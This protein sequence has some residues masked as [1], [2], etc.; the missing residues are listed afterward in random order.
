MSTASSEQREITV[1]IAGAAGDGLDKTGDTL[2]HTASRLGLHVYAYNSYQSLI[3][4]GHTWLR[5]RIG[6]QK[7]TN[8]GD[9]LNALIA[10]NEDSLERHAPEVE[11]GGVIL[12][13]SDKLR[14]DP[15]LV[16]DGVRV[17]EVP[18][19]T[20]TKDL[21][22]LLPVMQ[23]TVVLGALI[24]V[25]GLEFDVMAGMLA[26]TF[27]HKG[28][29][30][31]EQ[32]VGVARVGYDYARQNLEPMGY[33]WSF[34]RTRLPVLT[35]NTAMA[36]GAVAAGC[37]FYAAYPM[38]PA[39]SILHWF[40]AHGERCGVAVKQAEDELAVA[41]MTIGAGHAGVRAM[42]AT[43]GGGFALMTEAIG[44]ASILEAPAVFINVQRGGPSTGL[45][46]KTEQ[47]DLNQVFGAS[48]GDYPRM[49]VAP[50]NLTDCYYMTV[51]AFNIAEKFQLPVIMISDLLL[52][53]HVETV[54]ADALKPDVPI[55]RGE[56]IR[57]ASA[58]L[59][60][61]GFKRYTFTPS[62]VSPRVLPGTEGTAYVAATDD[63]DET[64]VLISDEH[65]NP[66]LRRKS[67]EKRMHKLKGVLAQLPPP[68]L[69]GP[70]DADVTLIGW[71][72]TWGVI[73]EAASQLNEIGIRANHL[74]IRYLF[75]FHN[76][77]VREILQACRRTAVVECNYTGQFARHLRAE[78]GFSVD[79]L[80]L[81]Y[82]GEPFEPG[83]IVERV[84][85]ILEG[86]PYN[87]QVAQ[88]EAREMAYHYIR[89]YLQE[90]ARPVRFEQISEGGYSE[91]VWQVQIAAREGGK[92]LGKLFIGLE[93][94][95]IHEWRAEAVG[96]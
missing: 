60:S 32:N 12:F 85:A 28:P 35:G 75:P 49:I 68:R 82:N 45:P 72:S 89:V 69:E 88:D 55:E 94:G 63:H 2:A 83:D 52:G 14:C 6:E 61:G 50:V 96:A 5:L 79:D 58:A 48:Q 16:R 20:L 8:H 90:D 25:I 36:M 40:M 57:D 30:I 37:K 93:T 33:T 13:N 29:Q 84:K 95:S 19:K 10:L 4:G 38:S 66:A 91:P 43:S 47:G 54:E 7:V 1:G 74:H 86:R 44:M 51:E 34:T 27:A 56:L 53:Q 76:R 65:T 64:G 22:K 31:I 70:A 26:D 62:G 18:F 46:T 24:H 73:H 80:I 41:N 87:G 71:G 78:T 39:S 59:M 67:Q 77:E 92:P 21:G 9:H 15:F 81:K 11:P 17:L 3:R 23:N 42:C